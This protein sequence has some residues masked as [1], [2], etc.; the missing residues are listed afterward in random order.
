MRTFP[1]S[2]YGPNAAAPTA[3]R[4]QQISQE[5]CPAAVE[6]YLGSKY[7]PTSKFTIG[8]LWSGEKAW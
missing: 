1:G 3:A 5:Q 6:S 7:D 8:M 2:E 4:I